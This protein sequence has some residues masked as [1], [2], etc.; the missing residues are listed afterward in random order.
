LSVPAPAL[1]LSEPK[2]DGVAPAVAPATRVRVRLPREVSLSWV[3]LL[4]LAFLAFIAGSATMYYQVSP[5]VFLRDAFAAG[6]ALRIRLSVVRAPYNPLLWKRARH[7]PQGVTVYDRSKAY[8]GYMLLATG[9]GA[10]V[11]LLNND[12]RV[13]HAWRKPYHELRDESAAQPFPVPERSIYFR[14]AQALP[15]GD[16]VAIYE[17]AGDTP[18]GYGIVKLDNDSNVIWKNLGS[19]H[20]TF[21]FTP[22][23]G[24][25]ALSHRIQTEPFEDTVMPVPYIDDEVVWLDGQG[26]V[27]QTVSILGAFRHSPYEKLTT[28]WSEQFF[29]RENGDY[30][31]TNDVEYIDAAKA[32]V[33]PFA[34]EGDVLISLRSQS[35][36]AVIDPKAKAVR[37]AKRGTW[38]AQH[39]PDV[40]ENGHLRLFDNLGDLATGGSRVIEFDPQTDALVWEYRSYGDRFLHSYLRSSSQGLPNGN[41]LITES[42]KGHVLEVTHDKELVW[43]YFVEERRDGRFPILS[44]A[45]KY[46]KDWFPFVAARSQIR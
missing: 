27:Q 45:R 12:G 5:G 14:D 23:G 46:P 39:D 13:L 17:G 20:H 21:D 6:K 8:D 22:D 34:R 38:L 42:D 31:H 19:F 26:R 33:L 9:A 36:L 24:V 44:D 28:R 29:V 3:Q 37:W 41:I 11:T 10:T 32:K 25:V 43:D 40:L 15:G 4:G 1:P 35:L 18:W 30:L 7:L 16:I 2:P